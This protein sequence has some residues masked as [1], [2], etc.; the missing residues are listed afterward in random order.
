MRRGEARKEREG[1]REEGSERGGM[2]GG[3]RG[4]AEGVGGEGEGERAEGERVTKGGEREREGCSGYVGLA[5]SLQRERAKI[6]PS[7][8]WILCGNAREF[9]KGSPGPHPLFFY[10]LL[11]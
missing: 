6:R 8:T 4:W 3:R 5:L 2:E 7:A 9:S 11:P 10:R 1:G